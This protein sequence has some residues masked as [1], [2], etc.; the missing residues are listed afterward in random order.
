MFCLRNLLVL[1]LII[2]SGFALIAIP[3]GGPEPAA[4]PAQVSPVLSEFEITRPAQLSG[5]VV[6][7]AKIGDFEQILILDLDGRQ[8]RPL[9]SG[10]SNNSYPNWSPDGESLVFTSDRDGNKEIYLADWDGSNQRRL[11]SNNVTDDNPAFSPD[12][13]RIVYH[14]ETGGKAANPDTNIFVMELET[15]KAEQVTAFQSRNMTPAFS[16]DGR[17]IAYSTN[18]FWPGW[19]ICLWSLSAK[20]ESCILRGSVESFCRPAWSPSGK[21]LAYS[22]GNGSDI[23]ISVFNFDNSES[24][25]LTSLALR[26][27]DVAWSPTGDYLAF[28]AENGSEGNFNIH[29]WEKSSQ[30]TSILT[31]SAYPARYLSWSGV[32]TIALEGKRMLGMQRQDS[33]ATQVPEAQNTPAENAG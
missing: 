23:N 5:R 24:V 12:G 14:S 3:A 19:D 7:S 6:F 20:N 25:E 17:N 21:Q 31:K 11:T 4:T 30:K 10:N 1:A 22:H 32:P 26:E 15:G 8:V 18:R 13:K 33:E 27:Y 2:I 16:P 28:V 29:L 9:V